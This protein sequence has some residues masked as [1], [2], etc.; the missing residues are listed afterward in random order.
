MERLTNDIPLLMK[1]TPLTVSTA[2]PCTQ[3]ECHTMLTNL[4]KTYSVLQDF[5]PKK[6]Q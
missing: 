1:T 6:H 4:L 2:K 3:I 5:C